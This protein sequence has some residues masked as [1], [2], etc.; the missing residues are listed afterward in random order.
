MGT[1]LP[2]PFIVFDR[3]SRILL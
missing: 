3:P 1:C 2:I